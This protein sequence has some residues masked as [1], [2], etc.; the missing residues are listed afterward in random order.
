MIAN[1]CVA[2]VMLMRGAIPCSRR[3]ASSGKQRQAEHGEIVALDALEQL[4]AQALELIG[5]DGV[6][7]AS[8]A[9]AR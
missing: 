8:P 5:A 4:R 3:N 2:A 9:R 1:I 6:Q 7:H